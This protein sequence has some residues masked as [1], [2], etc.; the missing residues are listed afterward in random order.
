MISVLVPEEYLLIVQC[1]LY[2]KSIKCL[3]DLCCTIR[4]FIDGIVQ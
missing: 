3:S 1:E 2:P 4:V